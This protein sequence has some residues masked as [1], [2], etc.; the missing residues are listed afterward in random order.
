MI[1]KCHL[2]WMRDLSPASNSLVLAGC[3][4]KNLGSD[5]FEKHVVNTPPKRNTPTIAP[6][7]ET[8]NHMYPRC[9][10][11]QRSTVKHCTVALVTTNVFQLGWLEIPSTDFFSLSFLPFFSY[12]K[13]CYHGISERLIPKTYT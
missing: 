9:S 12:L 13:M 5:S 3:W 11:V 2:F 6:S 1:N 4:L 8:E 7:L 10:T